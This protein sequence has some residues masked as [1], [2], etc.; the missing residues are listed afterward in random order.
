MPY[1]C[2][3]GETWRDGVFC[4]FVCN[5]CEE[6]KQN[7]KRFG[8]SLTNEKMLDKFYKEKENKKE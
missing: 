5:S 6:K 8:E 1:C 3:C 4:F 2:E 7:K